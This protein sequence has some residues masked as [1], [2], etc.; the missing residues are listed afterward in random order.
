MILADDIR[1]QCRRALA[2]MPQ[3][4]ENSIGVVS[5]ELEQK[6]C[7]AAWWM[8]TKYNMDID[9]HN[10]HDVIAQYDFCK[11]VCKKID[12]VVMGMEIADGRFSPQH[13]IEYLRIH[14]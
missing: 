4:S 12:T 13:L 14:D 9:I 1:K 8:H 10:L 11:T 5:R 7:N 3:E 6:H 2:D